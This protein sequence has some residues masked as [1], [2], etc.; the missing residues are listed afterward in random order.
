M[1]TY[2]RAAQEAGRRRPGSHSTG[3]RS[4]QT[5]PLR[6]LRRQCLSRE[7]PSRPWRRS[8]LAPRSPETGSRHAS[9]RPSRGAPPRSPRRFRRHPPASPCASRLRCG[10]AGP[11]RGR[12]APAR[13]SRPDLHVFRLVRVGAP[14]R[15]AQGPHRV[16]LSSARLPVGVRLALDLLRDDRAVLA[17][18]VRRKA[19]VRHG[20]RVR[21]R[22]PTRPEGDEPFRCVRASCLVDRALGV[23]ISG[24]DVVRA[25]RNLDAW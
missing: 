6:L 4:P 3:P 17:H 2:C 18:G 15:P 11:A 22:Q 13:R 14:A 24:T 7:G 12:S 8:P 9:P 25:D 16:R 1:G 10:S 23:A 21:L 20:V 19:R 5:A